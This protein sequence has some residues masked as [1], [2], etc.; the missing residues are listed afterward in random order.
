MRYRGRVKL[1]PLLFC[2]ALLTGAGACSGADRPGEPTTPSGPLT[3]RECA[4]FLDHVIDLQ[5][6]RMRAERPPDEIPDP[7]QVAEIRRGLK[8]TE[9]ERCLAQPRATYRC[10]MDAVNVAEMEACA[11]P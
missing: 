4:A 11:G 7:E 8:E 5:L 3:E 6:D 1:P 10:A 9:M 2:L